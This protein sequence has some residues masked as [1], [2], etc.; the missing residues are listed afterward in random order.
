MVFEIVSS[1]PNKSNLIKTA[2]DVNNKKT[3][4]VF[5]KIKDFAQKF[6]SQKNKKPLM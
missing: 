6:I 3:E 1:S 5:E 2:R 4:W